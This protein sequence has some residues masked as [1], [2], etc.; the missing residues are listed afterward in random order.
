M[1][2]STD[3]LLITHSLSQRTYPGAGDIDDCVPVATIQAYAAMAGVQ[4]LPTIPEFR[5]A[6][7]VPDRPGA[8]G[9][10]VFQ[11][12]KAARALW[13]TYRTTAAEFTWPNFGH[14]MEVG[15]RPASVSVVSGELPK[16]LQFGFTGGHQITVWYENGDWWMVNPLQPAGTAAHRI[17]ATELH[18][19]AGAFAGSG[20]VQA[21]MFP[22]VPEPGPT[23]P[24]LQA[25]VTELR[26]QLAVAEQRLAQAKALAAQAAAV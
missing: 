20:N 19:A 6:A 22:R 15:R 4:K 1:A 5:A 9:M 10:T 18:A 21:V 2:A 8:T 25:Q 3:H 11:A 24:E 23:I 16:G 13:P 14:A 26:A 7:G 12:G 17:T